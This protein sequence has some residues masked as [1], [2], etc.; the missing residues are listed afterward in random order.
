MTARGTFAL[1][2]CLATLHAF[3][4]R[5]HRHERFV[6][7]SKKNLK[8]EDDGPVDTV[9]RKGAKSPLADCDFLPND[10]IVEFEYKSKILMGIVS[11]YSKKSKGGV[12][13]DVLTSDDQLHPGVSPRAI[14]FS[15]P[16]LVP[17]KGIVTDPRRRLAQYE[18]VR[19]LKPEQLG[20]PAL[21]ELCWELAADEEAREFSVDD[22]TLLM[23]EEAEPLQRYRTFR[24][25]TSELGRV[26]FTTL[27]HGSS[28]VVSFKARAAKT[29]QAAK[30]A[31][32]DL[33]DDDGAF[34][35]ICL[36]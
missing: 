36:A 8:A 17:Q 9:E 27:T 15:T 31:L 7:A 20:D 3:Q 25:L 19:R 13:Y 30:R 22:M 14:I 26:F 12:M 23:D 10:S 5:A 34:A 1:A 21:L 35:A 29:V 32:C 4:P 16:P 18:A 33:H 2:A 6:L 11:D 24:I 28:H